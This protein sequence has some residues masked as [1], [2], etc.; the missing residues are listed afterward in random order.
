[1]TKTWIGVVIFG[2]ALTAC[3]RSK[4]ELEEKTE[5]KDKDSIAEMSTAAQSHVEL[6]V[7]QTAETE[8]KEYLQVSGT[9]QPI[10][11]RIGHVRPLA[12]GRLQDILAKVGDRVTKGQALARFDNI[13]A[14]ELAAQYEA[15]QAELHKLKVQQATA[16]RQ[17]ERSRRLAEIG[18]VPRKDFETAKSEEQ[19]LDASIEGQQSVIAGISARLKRF[20]LSYSNL[21]SSTQSVIV[22]P[23]SGVVIKA[24]AAPGEVVAEE[25]DLFQIADLSRVW[26]QAEVYEKDLAKLTTGQQAFITVDTYPDQKFMGKVMYIGDILD[27]QTRTTRVRCEVPNPRV[28]LKL[29]MFATVR[30]PTKFSRH[31][32]AVPN[33][34]I[35]Q[36]EDKNFVFVQ[37]APTKFMAREVGLGK[38]INSETEV[39]SGLRPGEPI[40]VNGSF[41]LKSIVRSKQL[42]EE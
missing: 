37:T 4:P 24:T 14:G 38:V 25:T 9:V 27:P 23:F 28:E 18:A 29:D 33:S 20:G 7:A 2:F 17:A 42:G 34:A 40:V 8:L 1:M 22:S 5:A 31:G 11:S 41:H 13:E 16:A 26:V 19:S 10:D 3:S 6:K 39:M 21:R 12:K 35:Q 32:L 30:L 15:G 36:W